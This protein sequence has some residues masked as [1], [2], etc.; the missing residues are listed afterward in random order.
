MNKQLSK[1]HIA[2]LFTLYI[3]QFLGLGFFTEAFIAI[4]RK[5]GMPLE[6]LGMVYMLGLFWVLRFLWAPFID[7]IKFERFG[8]YR[9]WLFIVQALMAL[10]LICTSFYDIKNHVEI[11]VLFAV[12]FSFFSATQDIALDALVYKTVSKEQRA[13]GN[14]IKVSGG[15]IGTVLGGGAGLIVYSYIGWQSTLGIMTL[16]TTISILQLLFFKEPKFEKHNEEEVTIK[17]CFNFWTQKNRK[18][19]FLLIILYPVTIS[20]A[21][22]LTIPILVDNGWQLDKIGFIVH[23]IGYGIGVLASFTAS[24]LVN[25]FGKKNILVG[26]AI[27]QAIGISL[28]LLPLNGFIDEFTI[29]FIVSFIFMF[30]TPSAT[31]LSTLMMDQITNKNQAASQY[32]IQ[33]SFYMLSGIFFAGMSVFLAGSLGYEKVIILCFAIGLIA[34]YMSTKLEDIIS[35]EIEEKEEDMILEPLYR[36]N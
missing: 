1:Q 16:L 26:S 3:S 4:L 11:I 22:G 29:V 27:G 7:K 33:H 35:D 34:I 30:Y 21:H 8:H 10:T 9:T 12:A 20:S 19:W 15:L 36:K 25:R 32:A 23:I 17:R 18:K 2:L 31:I 14:A 24:W 28:L 5:A 6:N 13:T